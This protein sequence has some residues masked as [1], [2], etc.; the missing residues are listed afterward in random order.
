MEIYSSGGQKHNSKLMLLLPLCLP[1]Y[2]KWSYGKG[3]GHQIVEFLCPH[4]AEKVIHAAFTCQVHVAFIM[5][6]QNISATHEV[7][8][9]VWT[10]SQSIKF[11]SVSSPLQAAVSYCLENTSVCKKQTNM[12]C[13]E[14]YAGGVT[15]VC[16]R[17]CVRVGGGLL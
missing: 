10:F 11:Y 16:V 5:A 8:D 12:Q 15:G 9:N 13:S 6:R 1:N 3:H 14:V 7:C 4:V 2:I 17:V